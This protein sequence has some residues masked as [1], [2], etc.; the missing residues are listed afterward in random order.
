[1]S[2]TE[3]PPPYTNPTAVA[4]NEI[5]EAVTDCLSDCYSNWDII[6]EPDG[7]PTFDEYLQHHFIEEA[8]MS[9]AYG[10]GTAHNNDKYCF[11]GEGGKNDS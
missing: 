1:M 4:M 7:K 2:N 3:Q 6:Y 10:V 5:I 9:Q 8:L 11:L